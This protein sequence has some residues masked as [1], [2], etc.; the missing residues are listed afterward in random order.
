[1]FAD[2]KK[3]NIIEV[4][5][6][7]ANKTRFFKAFEPIL[8]RATKSRQDNT[9]IM[10]VVLANAIRTGA[11]KMA[12][13]S[14]FDE[15]EL[16]TA[17]ASYV[18]HET[19]TNAVNII[20]N[21]AAKF[22]IYKQWYINSIMHASLDG[23]KLA[24]SVRNIKARYSS[25]FFGRG[26]GVSSY[27]EIFNYFSLASYLIGANEYEGNFTF[28]M[29]HH[30]N[31]S[32]IKPDH[33]ATDMHGKNSF[34]D[35]LFELTDL[36]FTPRIPKPHREILW[37]FGCARDYNGLLIKPTKF[38]KEELF[39]AEWDNIPKFVASMLTG[40]TT[41]SIVISKL[42][43]KNYNSN[44][45]KAFVQYNNIVRSQFLLKYLHDVKFRR[46]I[47]IAL[48]RG[49]AYNNL[50]RAITLLNNGELRGQSEI[51]M[52]IW[53]Q[54]TRL[55]AS[56]ILYYNTYILNSL[57]HHAKDPAE[58]QFIV[59]LSPGAW[60]HVNFLGHYKFCEKFDEKS[61]DQWLREWHWSKN[62]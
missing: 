30:Q 46:A 54:C 62:D 39:F 51:E 11:R 33:I 42:S 19:L 56:I 4:I 57:Y 26:M 43:S 36:M 29:V 8:P 37:G 27:N 32:D 2:F 21:A 52:E 28:E 5:Q 35:G 61:F 7:V 34:N 6:F 24:T 31:S 38:I 45:K 13:I 40:E 58:K 15:S 50:Y 55:I 1:M 9:R 22:P 48:N 47:L 25:K 59:D 14:D 53:N 49:E 44:T 20:N 3:R 17:E 60:V 18:R 12:S 41:P 23:L 10:A 16:I